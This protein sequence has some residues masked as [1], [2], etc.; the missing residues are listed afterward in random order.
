MYFFFRLIHFFLV[1]SFFHSIGNASLRFFYRIRSQTCL[2]IVVTRILKET[3]PGSLRKLDDH[4]PV[5]STNR[6]EVFFSNLAQDIKTPSPRTVFG[7]SY[8][9]NPPLI[10]SCSPDFFLHYPPSRIL[11]ILPHHNLP[12][13]FSRFFPPQE[14]GR[15][16]PSK[17]S[18]RGF[19]VCPRTALPP[20]TIFTVPGSFR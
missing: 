10:S 20:A 9:E 3:K 18:T 17:H 13:C 15:H 11:K 1:S 12:G 8:R 4:K 14:I 7:R 6:A 2:K 16:L 5:L 19:Q